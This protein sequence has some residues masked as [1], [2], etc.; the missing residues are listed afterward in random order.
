M[1]IYI[2]IYMYIY[3]YRGARCTSVVRVF[4]HGVMGHRIDPSWYTH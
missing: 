2:Y 3:I 1:Y 4:T